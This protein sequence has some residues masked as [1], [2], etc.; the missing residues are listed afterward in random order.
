MP[1][2]FSK[3]SFTTII[4]IT[5]KNKWSYKNGPDDAHSARLINICDMAVVHA[6]WIYLLK[7]IPLTFCTSP[8][9][10]INL[11]MLFMK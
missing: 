11:G 5:K 7:I 1:Y 6:F 8:F 10:K 2:K 4:I 3:K 9:L